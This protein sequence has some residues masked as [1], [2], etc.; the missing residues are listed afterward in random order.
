M[1]DKQPNYTPEQI[2]DPRVSWV[3]DKWKMEL[4]STAPTSE[5]I[6]QEDKMIE[7]KLSKETPE[8][9]ANYAR[10]HFE[11]LANVLD[12]IK[13]NRSVYVKTYKD[14]EGNPVYHVAIPQTDAELTKAIN[15][16]FEEKSIDKLS[17]N[18]K[19]KVLS[20]A[21]KEATKQTKKDLFGEK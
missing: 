11:N 14:K 10:R 5:N 21:Q 1:K 6:T 16:G 18:E 19:A 12:N 3:K 8:V 2:K 7:D 13:Q 4:P 20:E 17:D 9:Q 15:G